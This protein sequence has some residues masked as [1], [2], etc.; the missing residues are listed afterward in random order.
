MQKV[1]RI[2]HE[3]DCRPRV[4]S[5]FSTSASIPSHTVTDAL[6]TTVWYKPNAARNEDNTAKG[7]HDFG[8]CSDK[9][10]ETI[11]RGKLFE[12]RFARIFQFLFYYASGGHGFV[13]CPFIADSDELIEFM[14]SEFQDGFVDQNKMIIILSWTSDLF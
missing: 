13:L 11:R 9:I 2:S 6:L 4:L 8:G 5:L 3:L 10:P 14:R 1:T 7:R 12:P